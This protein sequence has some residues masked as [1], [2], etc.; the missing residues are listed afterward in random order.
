MMDLQMQMVA[1]VPSVGVTRDRESRV[2]FRQ[3]I[4][5]L[6]PV[7]NMQA[8]DTDRIG[9]EAAP[10][11]STCGCIVN[12]CPSSIVLVIQIL[13]ERAFCEELRCITWLLNA[14]SFAASNIAFEGVIRA[15]CS[16][17]FNFHEEYAVVVKSPLR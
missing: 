2:R 10:R 9:G 14:S 8:D 4:K 11:T 3:Y 12:P 6:E 17:T 16:P 15:P 1:S 5:V 13:P 7:K